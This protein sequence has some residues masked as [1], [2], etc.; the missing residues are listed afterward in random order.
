M[1]ITI[2]SKTISPKRKVSRLLKD[3]PDNCTYEDIHYHLYV[4]QKVEKGLNDIE[5]GNVYT[6]EEVKK[7][8]S[9]WLKK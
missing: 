9:K 4:L 7:K 1:P 3:L 8:L 5:K 6:H 2:K